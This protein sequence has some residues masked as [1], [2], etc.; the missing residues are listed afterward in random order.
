MDWRELLTYWQ[1]KFRDGRPP[2][3]NDLRPVEEV[4]SLLPRLFLIDVEGNQFRF[5]LI[6]TFIVARAGR[7][8][9]GRLIDETLMP[10]RG[11]QAWLDGLRKVA[12]TQEPVL[13]VTRP[14][15]GLSA[16]YIALAL[17]L[18]GED[19][20]TEMILGGLF[21]G[22]DFPFR[23][24]DHLGLIHTLVEYEFPGDLKDAVRPAPGGQSGSQ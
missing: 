20:S 24:E 10:E 18:V 16:E 15:S 11:P 14:S 13:G 12:S 1:S 22:Q 5:R 23:R 21:N 19:G 4:P 6:G 2:S 3:R 17:P 8:S 7:D 9:T